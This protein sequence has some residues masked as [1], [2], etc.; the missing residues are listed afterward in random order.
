MNL[1]MVI[2]KTLLKPLL[3][4]GLSLGIITVALISHVPAETSTNG[5]SHDMRSSNTNRSPECKMLCG[6]MSIERLKKIVA[7]PEYEQDPIPPVSKFSAVT[8]SSNV[9]LIIALYHS[10]KFVKIPIYEMYGLL[11]I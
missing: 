7:S 8:L 4:G 6:G 10:K 1:L 11:R 2:N 5:M 9:A 3:L